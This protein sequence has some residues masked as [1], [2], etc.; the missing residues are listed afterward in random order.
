M[1]VKMKINSRK[2]RKMMI[3]NDWNIADLIDKT[4]LS[5]STIS[6]ALN[7][8]NVIPSTIT[9]LYNALDIDIDDLIIWGS[10]GG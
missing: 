3:V 1:D 6:K 7:G 4:G 2:V 10:D 8:G 9:K 5:R